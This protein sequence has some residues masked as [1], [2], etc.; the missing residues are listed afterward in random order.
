MR[1]EIQL[2]FSS[3]KGFAFDTILRMRVREAF[4]AGVDDILF[5]DNPSP[6]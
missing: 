4:V 1:D 2:L 5:L 3:V 6:F